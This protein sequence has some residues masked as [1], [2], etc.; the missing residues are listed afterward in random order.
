MTDR[1]ALGGRVADLYQDFASGV[2]DRREFMRRSAALG[3]A[4]AA[5]GALAMLASGPSA[6]QVA[7]AAAS[8]T[9]AAAIDVAEWS[10]FWLGVKRAELARGTVVNGSQ[11]YV[12]YWIP[13]EVRHPYPMVIVHGGGGQ[14]PCSSGA[15]GERPWPGR[16]TR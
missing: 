11:M 7:A 9:G 10:Y 2:V 16:S 12:E 5:T 4:G 13:A 15:L 3:V 1:E 6:A 8:A 14:G